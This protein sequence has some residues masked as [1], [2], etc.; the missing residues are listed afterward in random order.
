MK[1]KIGD[2]VQL[3]HP[4]NGCKIYEIV[5]KRCSKWIGKSNIGI[6]VEF[7]SNE[8]EVLI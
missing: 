3:K 6:K 1:I 2:I 7:L 5:D 8:V 4:F